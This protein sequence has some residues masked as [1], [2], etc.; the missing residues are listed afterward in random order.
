LD[1]GATCLAALGSGSVVGLDVVSGAEV[2]RVEAH[3]DALFDVGVAPDGGAFVSGGPGGSARVWSAR[4]ELACELVGDRLAPVEHVAWAPKGE[5]IAVASARTVRLWTPSGA[6][7]RE[8]GPLE[9][10][11]TGLAWRHDGASL[12]ASCYG[13]VRVWSFAGA[14]A[15]ARHLPWK[16][17][18]ISLRWSP[19]GKVIACGTQDGAVHFWRLPTGRDSEMS[20]YPSKPRALAWDAGSTLLATAGDLM[21]TLWD[22]RDRGPEGTRPLVLESHMAPVSAL[23]FGARRAVLATGGHDA[24]V[25][26]WEPRRSLRPLGFAFLEDEVSAL[27]WHRDDRGVLAGDASGNVSFLE[28]GGAQ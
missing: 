15:P 28:S 18:L 23:A 17:S 16:G 9:G 22:F 10:A 3:P 27:A 26:L 2:F 11:A 20:G 5:R 1:G 6:P 14:D 24:A 7:V 21:V 12:A 4:G 25:M 13:G 8:V 19:D